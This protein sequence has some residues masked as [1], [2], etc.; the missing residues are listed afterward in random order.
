[1]THEQKAAYVFAQSVC[2]LAEIEGMRAENARQAC[3]NEPPAY[4]QEDFDAVIEE[5][6]ISHFGVVK[7]FQG[8]D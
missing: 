7:F 1:M 8:G 5:Y 4:G 6:D 3:C 2:A